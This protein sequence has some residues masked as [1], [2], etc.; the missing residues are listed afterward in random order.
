MD[1]LTRAM[2]ISLRASLMLTVIIATNKLS[3]IPKPAVKR[4]LE[5]LSGLPVKGALLPVFF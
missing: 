3:V 5:Y 4:L 2:I 1:A